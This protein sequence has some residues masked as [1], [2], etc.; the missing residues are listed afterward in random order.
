MGRK[1]RSAGAQLEVEVIFDDLFEDAADQ[2]A[3]IVQ[4]SKIAAERLVA[5]GIDDAVV[6]QDAYAADGRTVVVVYQVEL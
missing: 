1:V 4:A 5:A 6:V 2:N 3:A